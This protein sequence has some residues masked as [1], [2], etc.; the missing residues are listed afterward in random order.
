[1]SI[2][3]AALLGMLSLTALAVA[4]AYRPQSAADKPESVLDRK[5]VIEMQLVTELP[6]VARLCDSLPVKRL[7]INVGDAQLYVEEEGNGVPLVL[8]NGG[9]GGTHHCFHPWFS[10]AKTFARVVY[11]DQRGTGLSDYTPGPNGYSVDQAVADLDAVRA[12]LGIDKWVVLGYSYG[13]F[14]AQLYAVAHPDRMMGLVL[15]GASPGMWTEMMPSRQ[16]EFLTKE[17]RDRMRQIRTEV[18]DRSKAEKWTSEKSM[19]VS[20]YNNHLNGDWKRQ[21]FFR[22]TPEQLARMVLYEW[23]FD[24]QNNFRG[25]IGN[26]QGKVDFTGAFEG[27]PAPTLILEGK[28]DLTW[29]TDKP[30]ILSRN[31]PGSQLVMFENA[32][33]AI[34]D[35]EPDRFFGV[36]RDFLQALP[37][38][39]STAVA[40]Y[41]TYV[42]GW[43]RQR[44]ASPRFLVRSSG[45]G[46]T[47]MLALAR[48]YTRAWCDT[49]ADASSFLKAGFAQYEAGHYAEALYVFEKMQAL[50]TK[51][52][53]RSTQAIGLIWQGHMLDLLGRRAEAAARYEQVVALSIRDSWVHSQYGLEYEVTSYAKERMTKPFVRVE[54]VEK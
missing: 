27:F 5:V 36:L 16:G 52:N 44:K 49:L 35:E 41:Q 8:I 2:P 25:G 6:K 11:Y 4:P 29:N 54:N 1:M 32:G 23:N 47:D 28:W 26:S 50:G 37:P 17:E 13:G 3:R 10:R 34:Y 45:Y 39:M 43:D 33:H 22:P 24:L 14:L 48:A 53:D 51:K 20:V 38:V 31:H 18:V 30:G 46:R 15:L 12:A 9:P 21:S 40:S 42:Q 19:A 7:K